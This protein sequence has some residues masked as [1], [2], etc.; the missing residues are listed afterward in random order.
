[1]NEAINMMVDQ[2]S[3]NG[4]SKHD[5]KQVFH[6]TVAILTG[7]LLSVLLGAGSTV[8]LVRSLGTERLGQ[9]S[10]L[11]AYVTL[12]AWM[13]SLGIEPV[14]TLEAVRNRLNAGS[15]VA[16][17][18]ALCGLSAGTASIIV[19]L[20]APHV[21]Y[22]GQMQLLV[23]LVV[24]ELLLL[25]PLR[26]PA[27]VFQVDLKQWYAVAINLIRQL[28]WL[29]T[30]FLLARWHS[31]LT[32]FILGKLGG[33]LAE[34]F[35][36]FV[37]TASLLP[38]PRRVLTR[39]L[40]PYLR[41]CI[42]IAFSSLLAALYLRVD[43]VML[44]N[45]VSDQVLGGYAAAVKISELLEMIPA[46]LLSSLFPL[47]AGIAHDQAL[48]NSYVDRI[49]R[50]MMVSV[51][52]LCVVMSLGSGLIVSVLYGPGFTS[53]ARVLRILVWSE[54]AIFFASVVIN[55]L[56]ARNL[57]RFLLY[58]TAMGAIVNVLLNLFLI[59]R[60]A[61]SGSAW[62][63]VISYTLGWMVVL[64]A[65]AS[66]RGII[67]Q[68]LNH[69]F[70][71]CLLALAATVAASS[72]SVPATVQIILGLMFYITGAWLI[73]ALRYEDLEYARAIVNRAVFKLE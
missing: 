28:L 18:M 50:Y 48:L 36:I 49:F 5:S 14:L 29:G 22:S 16:T 15:I 55:V 9:F 46:A 64:L 21:G 37:V 69:A 66:T 20:L 32:G 17:G 31:P 24:V 7:R 60:F 63:S 2:R 54:F 4:L 45:L 35:L 44:H 72:I 13:A 34:L 62:A 23:I 56:I 33:A 39:Q 26:L 71:L 73:R 65:F 51:G 30:I 68:G 1:M 19:I 41:A 67:W 10:A 42:P 58:P 27:I 11:Y 3:P 61:A 40:K 59:P 47:L 12:F 53:T 57:Q 43:Q 70:P 8:L 6:N 25:G 38:P 52:G